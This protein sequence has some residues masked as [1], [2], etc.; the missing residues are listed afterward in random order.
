MNASDALQQADWL[1][2][3]RE[4][5][6]VVLLEPSTICLGDREFTW[7][8]VANPDLLLEVAV[9]GLDVPAEEMDPFW[10]VTW[11]AAQGLDRFLANIPLHDVRILEL[12]CG[13]G[14]AGTGAAARGGIV[15]VTDAVDLAL[16]VARLNAW[17]VSKQMNFQRLKWGSEQL[18]A[19][20]FPLVIGS[21][22]VYDPQLFPLLERCARQHLASDGML[23]LSEPHRH[24]GDRFAKW[25]V[26]AGWDV[27]EHDVDL[28]DER[29]PIR[30]F[31]CTLKP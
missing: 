20:R 12:G 13:S 1:E 15:T 30:V 24:T 27:V 17:P 21:D 4:I 31:A 29:V 5:E 23:L 7:Y 8:R 19:P 3:K 28:R 2:L 6:Q 9:A 18:D 14:Q 16:R 26:A 10:S 22:L 25:I 11:R